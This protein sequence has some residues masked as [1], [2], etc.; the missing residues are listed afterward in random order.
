MKENIAQGWEKWKALSKRIGRF[1]ARIFFSILY[2]LVVT[3]V[4]FV[5]GRSTRMKLEKAPHWE[6]YT[7]APQTLL[8]MTEQ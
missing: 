7:E 5:M 4:G 8:Q 1:Q 6:E 2:Y 3:P